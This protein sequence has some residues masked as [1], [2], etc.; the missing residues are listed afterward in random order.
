MVDPNRKINR[1]TDKDVEFLVECEEE[2]GDRYSHD[3]DEFMAHCAKPSAAP[4]IVENWSAAVYGVGNS[5]AGNHHNNRSGPGRH[6]RSWRG[7]NHNFW[8]GNYD[9]R[10]HND[11][12][13]NHQNR[14]KIYQKDRRPMNIRRDYNNFVA[15]SK[16]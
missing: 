15:A 5:G 10:R 7:G 16:D 2:F 13:D 12:R 6:Q 3:D 8:K 4:P 9:N 1:L 14:Y 11:N